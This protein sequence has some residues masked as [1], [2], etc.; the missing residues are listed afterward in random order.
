MHLGMKGEPGS[1]R[2][3]SG[4]EGSAPGNEGGAPGNEG[5]TWKRG[6]SF[7]LVPLSLALVMIFCLFRRKVSP[8]CF[9][10][11]HVSLV[12]VSPLA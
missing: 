6:Y 12:C 4:N 1:K 2:G 10:C 11:M 7:I 5:C 8:R 9:P 3:A